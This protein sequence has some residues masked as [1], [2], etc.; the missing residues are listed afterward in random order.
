MRDPAVRRQQQLQ[1]ED[2]RRQQGQVRRVTVA[3]KNRLMSNDSLSGFQLLAYTVL[4][5]T[6]LGCLG[7]S[8]DSI[9]VCYGMVYYLRGRIG[10][11]SSLFVYVLHCKTYTN[12]ANSIPMWPLCLLP[13]KQS[14]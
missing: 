12:K 6:G 5:K 3:G 11:H 14:V 2:H 10:I 1:Q 9:F 4:G 13:L 7:C 8:M